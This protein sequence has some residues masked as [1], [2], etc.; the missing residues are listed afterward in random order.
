MGLATGEDTH[1]NRIMGPQ[2]GRAVFGLKVGFAA[3]APGLMG[4]R[5][6]RCYVVPYPFH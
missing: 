6:A 5:G 3:V 1:V 4:G 2:S